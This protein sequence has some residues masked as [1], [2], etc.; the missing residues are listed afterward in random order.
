MAITTSIALQF[1]EDIYLGVHDFSADTFK[2]AL[3]ASTATLNE[4]TS[5]YTTSGEIVGSAYSAGGITLTGAAVSEASGVII[6][7]FDDANIPSLTV[8]DVRGCMI[9]N[10]S[11]SNKTF[12]CINFGETYSATSTEFNFQF[13]AATAQN[14]FYRHYGTGS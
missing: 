8:A 6:I 2:M 3:Y 12:V 14:G 1:K 7:T 5:V 9:Y 11:K 13:P 10:S 4:A